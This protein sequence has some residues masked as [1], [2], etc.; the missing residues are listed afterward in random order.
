MKSGRVRRD[1]GHVVGDGLRE[2]L[3][4]PLRRHGTDEERHLDVLRQVV[5]L[6]LGDLR[7][8]DLAEAHDDAERA[9]G[10]LGRCR[11]EAARALDLLT[12]VGERELHHATVIVLRSDGADEDRLVVEEVFLVGEHRLTVRRRERDA[13]RVALAQTNAA[14]P[15]RSLH[16]WFVVQE[17]TTSAIFS[18]TRC[19]V[20]V[21]S[22]NSGPR[23]RQSLCERHCVESSTTVAAHAETTAETMANPKTTKRFDIIRE[24]PVCNVCACAGS[25][26]RWREFRTS[27]R[28]R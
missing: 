6:R 16:S 12:R 21:V 23:A 3:R 28:E 15:L 25:P 2:D 26:S 8:G 7:R 5:D 22:A 24:S 10:P 4:G 17:F 14:P 13:L 11:C 18:Q 20:Q 9:S 1:R 19:S 27:F